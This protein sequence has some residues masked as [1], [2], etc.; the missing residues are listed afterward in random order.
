MLPSFDYVRVTT[1]EDACRQ[2]RPEGAW[3]HAGGTD[4]IGCLH[5]GILRGEKI[6][7]L[8]AL[9]RLRGID[10]TRDGGMRIGA[11]TTIREVAEH[12]GLRERYRALAMAASEVASP[13]LRSQG[14]IGGNICQKPRCSYYRG[15]FHCIRKGGD[16]CYAFSGRHENHCIFGGDRC[17]VVHPSDTAPALV[18]LRA[19]ATVA[20]PEGTRKIPLESFHVLPQVDPMRETVL[21]P[22]EIVTEILLPAPWPGLR[23]SYRK[24]RARRA[25]DFAVAG[26]ALAFAFD[27]DVVR[28]ARVVLSGAAPVP[29]RSQRT[30]DSILG[31]SLDEETIGIACAA[32]VE[33]AEPLPQNA[34][35]VP[36]FKGMLEEEL[37]K[38]AVG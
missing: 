28:D 23:G 4:L 17:Y 14:T 19:T 11:R 35:K 2:S 33:E 12:A 20:G 34:Y 1:I 21:E 5:D 31:R 15:D 27:R 8:K 3:V 24:V 16:Q 26:V 38:L 6:V 37:R 29:W 30:E 18:A 36:L 7:S 25:W 22:G 32:V 9:D 10:E 13:Q